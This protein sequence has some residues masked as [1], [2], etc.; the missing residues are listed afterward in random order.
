MIRRRS[1][2]FNPNIER[3]I[4]APRLARYRAKTG[5]D[6]SAWALYRWNI[7]L[8]TAF[9][10]LVADLEVSLR[11]TIH[12]QLTIWYEREDWW[13]SSSLLLDDVTSEMLT[14]VVRKHQKKIAKG[15]V[16]PGKVI[17]DATLGVWINLLGRG[18]QSA[19][20]RSIDYETKLWR[21]ALRFG[22]LSGSLT[23]SGRERRPKR[24]DVHR[25]A[26]NFQKLRNRVA[27]H[28]PIFDGIRLA[29][30]DTTKPLLEI[31]QESIELLGWICPDLADL[32]R[33]Y[34]A[35]PQVHDGRPVA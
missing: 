35:L 3:A 24:L 32:H 6:E 26:L 19:L 1:S 15:T 14:A 8:S 7:A 33:E 17:A 30:V 29:G 31:W 13:A 28:E 2:Y 21:P 11:N 9:G 34:N 25:R 20:G 18:G 22:F 16:P 27:H 12:D 23:S 4:S 5:S 10:P